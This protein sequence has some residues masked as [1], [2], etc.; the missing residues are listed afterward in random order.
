MSEFRI[1]VG[2]QDLLF[3][4]AHFIS[5]EDGRCESLHGHNYR[6]RAT[7][8]GKLNRAGYVFDY[9]ELKRAVARRIETLD[10]RVLLPSRSPA[11]LVH[12]AGEQV[13]VEC[14][15]PLYTFPR[16]D[17]VLLPI[18]NTTAELLAAWLADELAAW[19]AERAEAGAD[20][21]RLEVE[22]EECP[23]QS[24]ICRRSLVEA[25]SSEGAEA[26]M[27]APPEAA[28]QADPGAGT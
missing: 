11:I 28:P 5:F 4:A 25:G 26:K 13:L 18:S 22:V 1:S 7:L 19:L 27:P 21:Q 23:G 2:K 8:D 10:H 6:V 17:V 24:G 20:F 9:V 15:D 12:E 14:G 3:S 16:A